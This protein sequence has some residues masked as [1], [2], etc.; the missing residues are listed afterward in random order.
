MAKVR[1]CG[2]SPK[3]KSPL[4]ASKIWNKEVFGNID[5]SIEKRDL[6]VAKVDDLLDC[7]GDNK[8][9][10]ARRRALLSDLDHWY[11]KRCLY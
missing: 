10:L 9:F 1:K 6:E 11:N 3:S 5:S 4:W 2:S 7:D 8:E